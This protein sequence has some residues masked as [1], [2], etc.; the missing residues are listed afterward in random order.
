ML[1]NSK[2]KNCF[3]LGSKV[4]IYVPATTGIKQAADNSAQVDA[5]LK[6]LSDLFG[7][8]TSTNALGAW[9]SPT[10]GLVKEH[11]TMVFA[12][13]N[14]EQLEAAIGQ[15]VDYCEAL[16]KEMTQDAIALEINGEMYFI[17]A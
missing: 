3:K 8:A 6:L 11:T 7:G 16:C 17:E 10:A 9:V 13:C 12:Y 4:T 15:I 1:T 5:T 2:L 14:T